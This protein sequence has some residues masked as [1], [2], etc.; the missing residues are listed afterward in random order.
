MRWFIAGSI[1]VLVAAA[2]GW[3]FLALRKPAVPVAVQS[4]GFGVS[5]KPDAATARPPLKNLSEIAASPQ[6]GAGRAYNPDLDFEPNELLVLDPP[7]GFEDGAR[8]LGFTIV[9][10]T[11]LATLRMNVYR[12]RIPSRSTV[13]EAKMLLGGRFPGAVIDVHH[14]FQAQ[15]SPAGAADLRFNARMAMDWEKL[16]PTCGT[17]VRLGQIDSPV[18]LGHPALKSQKITYRS[19][20]KESRKPG[21]ADHGTAIAAMLVGTAAWGGI[22]PGASLLAANMF[23]VS[24]TGEVV[25]NGLALIKAVEWLAGEKV[26]AVNLSIAGSDN[27]VVRKAFDHAKE[28]GLVMIAA[29]GNWGRN[30][31]PAYPAAYDDVAAVTAVKD[32]ELIYSEANTGSY[33]DFA[34]PGVRLWTAAP[35]GGGAFQSG[36]SFA[37]PYLTV[38]M[39]TAVSHGEK[40]NIDDLIASYGKKARDLGKHGKDDI[41]GWGLVSTPPV[42]Q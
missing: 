33:I 19:F 32:K 2:T 34:A 10:I 39:A 37:T 41:F 40:R 8:S 31:K 21:P 14:H 20:H 11:N 28:T 29:A 42:C 13:P 30:D 26:H 22:L 18:D 12:V 38:L 5:A 24:E 16:S 7:A 4:G 6:R 1:L 23:E 25:G 17:G 36:T 3:Y 15:G 27:K 9:E 35:G